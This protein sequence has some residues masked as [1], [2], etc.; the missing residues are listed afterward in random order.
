MLA[1]ILIIYLVL[2]FILCC[3][4]VV[5][6]GGVDKLNK[7]LPNSSFPV[8]VLAYFVV[9]TLVAPSLLLIDG[10]LYLY[11]LLRG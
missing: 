8:S 5:Q 2:G 3:I 4:P 10:A 6:D 1:N 7:I 11:R 9:G